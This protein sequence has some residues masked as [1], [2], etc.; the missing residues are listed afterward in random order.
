MFNV[1]LLVRYCEFYFHLKKLIYGIIFFFYNFLLT[2]RFE[3][4][5]LKNSLPRQV[6]IRILNIFISYVLNIENFFIKF[7]F[8]LQ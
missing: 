8:R 3:F 4:S 1:I 2:E 5:M 7:R 6:R